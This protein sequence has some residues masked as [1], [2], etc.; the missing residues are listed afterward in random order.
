MGE[1]DFANADHAADKSL[2]HAGRIPE[3]DWLISNNIRML[4]NQARIKNVQKIKRENANV[5]FQFGNF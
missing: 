3:L 1:L 2:K 5:Y 4:T